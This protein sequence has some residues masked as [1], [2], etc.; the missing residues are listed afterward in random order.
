MTTENKNLFEVTEI[1]HQTNSVTIR[2]EHSML[3]PI[4]RAIKAHD[5]LGRPKAR[6]ALG[7]QIMFARAILR[8]ENHID[9]IPQFENT[10]L[11]D[12]DGSRVEEEEFALVG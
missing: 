11:I 6:M 3:E 2:L 9:N 10:V 12:D 1:N 5:S 4:A 8:D 7:C